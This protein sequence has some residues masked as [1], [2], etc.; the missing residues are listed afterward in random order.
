MWSYKTNGPSKRILFFVLRERM[1]K[2][3]LEDVRRGG[4]KK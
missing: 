2:E 1:E 4:R 3:K